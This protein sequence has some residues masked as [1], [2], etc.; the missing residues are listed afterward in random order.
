[1]SGVPRKLLSLTAD[2][3]QCPTDPIVTV[4]EDASVKNEKGRTSLSEKK[5]EHLIEDEI[6]ILTPR[7]VGDRDEYV[8]FASR[9]DDACRNL[10]DNDLSALAKD[11]EVHVVDDCSATEHKMNGNCGKNMNVAANNRTLCFTTTSSKTAAVDTEHIQQGRDTRQLAT[12]DRMITTEQLRGK[13]CENNNLSPQQQEDLYNVLVK[14]QRHLTKRPGKCTKF[15]YE[16]K[17]E[18]SIPTSANSRPIPFALKDQVRDQIQAILNDDI[19]EESFSSYIK[20]LTL[21]VRERN[22]FVFA[23]MSGEL[24]QTARKCYLCANC[25]R[26]FMLQVILPAWT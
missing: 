2:P 10:H 9:Y 20:P 4:D 18:G 22:R 13:V 12:D 21:V 23:L 8:K 3:A 26:N 6:D 19:L 11:K 5:K 14:Y 7:R 15:E 17:I 16:L 25:S 24:L 1:M